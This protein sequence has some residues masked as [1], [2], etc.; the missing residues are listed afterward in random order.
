VV[1]ETEGPEA[2][3]DMF[4]G[5]FNDW[6]YG[7]TNGSE[8]TLICFEKSHKSFLNGINLKN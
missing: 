1:T 3:G 7:R 2:L 6:D 5:H 4:L 8:A